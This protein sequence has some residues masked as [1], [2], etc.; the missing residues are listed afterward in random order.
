MP[1]HVAAFAA[2]KRAELVER[3]AE[4]DEEL[5]ELFLEEAPIDA[6]ALRCRAPREAP[7]CGAAR[8]RASFPAHAAPQSP[9]L[10]P[11]LVLLQRAP[12]GGGRGCGRLANPTPA[13]GG[14]EA[15]RRAT[16]SL[17]FV[18]LFMGSAY[19]NRGVQLLLDGVREFLPCPLDVNNRALVRAGSGR[20]CGHSAMPGLH[21]SLKPL[22]PRDAMHNQIRRALTGSDGGAGRAKLL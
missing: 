12:A 20:P 22:N 13:P 4:V 10:H 2:A 19:K 9:L 16:L 8:R 15:V 6:A 18:P 14:R 1:E 3:V 21:K 5:G 17:Q 11:L 7:A